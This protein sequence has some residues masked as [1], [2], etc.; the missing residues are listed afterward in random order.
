MNNK[1]EVI[2][3]L[4]KSGSMYDMVEDAIGGY[5]RLIDD[6]KESD[7]SINVTTI[8]FS[9]DMEYLCQNQDIKE[10]KHLSKKDYKTGGMTALYDAVGN[11]I[12]EIKAIATDVIGTN[13]EDGVAHWLAEIEKMF[14]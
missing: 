13:E 4:D 1:S 8:L 2:F 7:V 14:F 11:A 10:V 6:L 3:I 9:S 5:N 12:E